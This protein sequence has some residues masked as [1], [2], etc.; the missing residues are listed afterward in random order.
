MS[1]KLRLS[2]FDRAWGVQRS[3]PA[4]YQ[5]GPAGARFFYRF[6]WPRSRPRFMGMLLQT[7]EGPV[8][9][10]I[11]VDRGNGIDEADPIT[12]PHHGTSFYA[13]R[14]SYPYAVKLI[15]VDPTDKQA[16]FRYWAGFAS[17]EKKLDALI[18]SAAE[19]FGIT[20]PIQSIEVDGMPQ[21]P[22]PI[23]HAAHYA[24]VVELAKR[25]AP[26]IEPRL[27]ADGPLISFVVPVYNTPAKYL[28]D[29]LQSFREQPA[30]AAE[31]ILSDDGSTA[32]ETESWLARHEHA[33][34][35]R[36]FRNPKNQGIAAATNAGIDLARG[37]W[38][39]LLDHDDALSPCTVQ[40]LAQTIQDH[41]ECQFIYTDEVVAD[42]NLRPIINFL[43]PAYDE[44][45]LSGVN[46][47]NHL[48][49]Y[50]RERLLA[51]GGLRTGFEGSQDYDLVL[52]YLRDLKPGEV[53]HLPYPAYRWRRNP[54]AYSIKFEEQAIASARRALAQRYS[55]PD[56]SVAVGDALRHSLHR[57]RFDQHVGQTDGKAPMV[58]LIMPT[59]GKLSYLK[60]SVSGILHDTDYDNFELIVL[61]NSTTDQAA[62]PYLDEIAKD[63]RVTI[64]DSQSNFNFSRICNIGIKR[65]KGDIFG[66]V[67]DDLEI[68]DPNWLREMVACF[69]YPNTG[70]VGARLLY[71]NRR[72]QHVGVIVGL[73]GLAG[74]WFVNKHESYPGPMARLHV[75]QSFSAV[76]AACMLIS[77]ACSAGVGELDEENFAVAYNDIDYCLRAV[78]KGYRIVWTP[79][80]TLIHHESAT[81]GSDQ[82]GANLQRFLGDQERL[83]RLRGTHE[84]EDRA[85]SPWYTHDDSQ[86]EPR[87]LNSLPKSR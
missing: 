58:S 6:R 84:F 85:F 7:L 72:L 86:P 37:R 51:L 5:A 24:A 62:F 1:V 22:R 39:G 31:L 36:V 47:I 87:Q 10:K 68:V 21:R 41:P 53:K 11:Y 45:L 75:R 13:I 80:A 35:V 29:L 70:I 30:G 54:G 20:A 4:D 59:G 12:P 16:R 81:R 82:T 67:N 33:L 50:R 18:Q 69:Q 8:E 78:A 3:G 23:D 83:R 19:K 43:K 14:I 64:I 60:K 56:A 44:V 52:R 66:L 25:T 42:E 46:Y 49:C 73:G 79:F 9:P 28:D 77:R 76:T 48:S 17:S 71:P 15:R 63:P 61:Y 2:L 34:D 32:A 55:R 74:H 38:I 26:P 57:V 27:L 40:L 65:A